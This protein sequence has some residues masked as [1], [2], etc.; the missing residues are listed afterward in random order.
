M[1]LMFSFVLG[2]FIFGIVGI[3]FT[4]FLVVLYVCEE[5]R[6]G[7]LFQP[8][9]HGKTRENIFK[10]KIGVLTWMSFLFVFLI[11]IINYIMHRNFNY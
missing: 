3:L 2:F 4:S 5:E 10:A 9:L 6:S 1:S 11:Y 7:M 8:L